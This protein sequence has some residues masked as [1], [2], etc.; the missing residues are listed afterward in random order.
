MEK[1][2]AIK[3]ASILGMIG[4]IFLFVIKGITGFITGSQSMIADFFNSAGDIF[5]SIMTFIGNKI[6]S[7]PKDDDHNLGHG[8]AEYIYSLLISLVMIYVAF[9]VFKSSFMSLIYGKTYDFSYWLIIVCILTM[10]IKFSL[11]IYTKMVY[12]KFHNLLIKANSK[13]H[14]NDFLL[15][16]LNLLACF[17]SLSHIYYLDGIVGIVIALWIL[18]SGIKIFKESYDILMDKSIDEETKQKVLSIIYDHNE[19][20]KVIHFNS[21]PVGYQYQISFTIYVDG[22]LSTFR[23]HEIA[24]HLE[25]EIDEK[26][27]EVYLT[28]IHVNPIKIEKEE[29]T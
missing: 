7:Q 19:V 28:V 2:Q 8:K 21:T 12:N 29:A 1:F 17:S 20:K 23:S 18:I 14:R 25:K 3:K 22:N 5:S 10:I 27:P 9:Y 11:Y 6:S 16:S 26:I 15:T 13:D 4:N 24:N